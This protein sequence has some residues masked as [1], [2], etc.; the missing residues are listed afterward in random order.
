M[1]FSMYISEWDLHGAT[2]YYQQLVP[3]EKIY[4]QGTWCVYQRW[5][6]TV[7]LCTGYT[8]SLCHK[9]N[10]QGHGIPP[11]ISEWDLHGAAAATTSSSATREKYTPGTFLPC[12]MSQ[13]YQVPRLLPTVPT[14]RNIHP[15]TA[16]LHVY[17]RKER[18]I[19][20][21]IAFLHVYIRTGM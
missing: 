8:S 20:Q 16:T 17:I 9:G 13:V 12:C 3:R 18:N 19:H 11:C 15:R 6:L 21:D 14:R 7:L 4:T 1:A 2:G 5:D 10:T